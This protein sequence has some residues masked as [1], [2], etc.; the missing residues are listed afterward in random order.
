MYVCACP[1]NFRTVCACT[2]FCACAKEVQSVWMCHL[3]CVFG[4][5]LMW[6]NRWRRR[7]Q[8]HRAFLTP[9]QRRCAPARFSLACAALCFAYKGGI[10]HLTMG[11]HAAT[12]KSKGR[13]GI[14]Q[15]TLIQVISFELV[16]EHSELAECLPCHLGCDYPRRP[17][18]H[19]FKL[20]A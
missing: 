6:I 7:S 18:M 8:S 10:H 12:D 15:M 9:P 20:S 2:R 3:G 17:V 16:R 14:R 13:G 1:H 4:C 19:F 5:L 11:G